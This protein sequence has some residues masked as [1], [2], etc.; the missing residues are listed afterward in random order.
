MPY[1]GICDVASSDQIRY[2]LQY[3]LEDSSHCLMAGVMMSRKTLYGLPTKWAD[4]FP[5]KETIKDIFSFSDPRLMNTIHYA[6][7]EVGDERDRS[8][9]LTLECVEENYGGP[10]LD[11]IQLDMIWPSTRE[12]IRFRHSSPTQVVLQVGEKAMAMCGDDPIKVC[13]RLN[14]YGKTIDYVLFDKSMGKGKGMDASLL[15]TYVGAL[16]SDC[17]HLLPAVAGGIGPSSMHLVEPLMRAY[18]SISM[19]M[20]SKVRKSGDAKDP[21]DLWMAGEAVRQAI[22]MSSRL[23]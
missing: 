4:I 19:D 22:V 9:R 8:L 18:P 17:P 5:K 1:I 23:G 21:I 7:Y 3:F 12:L 20:Q 10:H 2:L 11:A 13:E 6:D 14:D 16:A 15:A